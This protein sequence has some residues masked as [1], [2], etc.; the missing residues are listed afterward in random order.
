MRGYEPHSEQ[1]IRQ[2]ARTAPDPHERICKAIAASGN[3]LQQRLILVKQAM[4]DDC[5]REQH[6][7]DGHN[8]A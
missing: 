4:Q 8:K 1:H 2:L 5:R 7:G 3:W 6:Q